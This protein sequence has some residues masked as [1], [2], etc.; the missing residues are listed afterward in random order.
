MGYGKFCTCRCF[1]T[2]LSCRWK[3]LLSSTNWLQLQPAD[4]AYLTIT[5]VP[6]LQNCKDC[7]IVAA[8]YEEEGEGK[9]YYYLF[10]LFWLK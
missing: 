8:S 2:L 9:Y 6:S 5:T 3:N 4:R 10:P 1:F 7:S